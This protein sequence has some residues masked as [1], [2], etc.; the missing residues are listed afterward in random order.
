[1]AIAKNAG[2]IPVSL[3]DYILR[4]ATAAIA[5]ASYLRFSLLE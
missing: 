3:G 1:M 2:F 5:V 4:V